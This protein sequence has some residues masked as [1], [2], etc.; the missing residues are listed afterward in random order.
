MP[1]KRVFA[2][3]ILLLACGVIPC[4]GEAQLPSGAYP[5][6]SPPPQD[7]WSMDPLE[8]IAIAAVI[9]AVVG[10]MGFTLYKRAELRSIQKETA[11]LKAKTEELRARQRQQP[12]RAEP[13]NVC[14]YC[15][16]TI[17]VGSAFCPV[18]QKAVR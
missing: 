15:R 3:I 16:A 7:N 17:N 12:I 1:I 18:C 2:L 9:V 10:A 13:V 4:V 8:L 6:F 14:K 5:S 11:I